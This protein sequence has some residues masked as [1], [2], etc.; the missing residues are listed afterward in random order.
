MGDPRFFNSFLHV[1]QNLDK[2][3]NSV[4]GSAPEPSG[5]DMLRPVFSFCWWVDRSLAL[6]NVLGS[7]Y[8]RRDD[9]CL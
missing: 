8:L 2:S 7:W 3:G 6:W 4:M 5:V 1:A 9:R